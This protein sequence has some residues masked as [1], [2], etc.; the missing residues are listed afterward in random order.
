MASVGRTFSKPKGR[1][2]QHAGEVSGSSHF[3][4]WVAIFVSR[5]SLLDAEACSVGAMTDAAGREGWM[6]RTVASDAEG[7]NGRGP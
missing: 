5:A 7:G 4:R 6:A 1:E 3:S 2:G